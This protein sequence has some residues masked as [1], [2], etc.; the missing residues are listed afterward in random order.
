MLLV[1][2]HE[3]VAEGLARLLGD[4]PDI[5]PV[6]V[7]STIDDA[8]QVAR[9][10]RPDLVLMDYRLPDGDGVH[11]TRRL[12]EEVPD[13]NVVVLTAQP[14]E[15]VLEGALGAGACAFV[16]KQ[17]PAA[18]LIAAVRAA[19]AG[20][21]YFTPDVLTKLVRLRRRPGGTGTQTLHP[22]EREVLQLVADGRSVA[23]IAAELHLSPHTVRNHVRHAMQKLGVHTRLEA[24]VAA[25]RVGLVRLEP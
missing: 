18:D 13:A 17:A 23:Q 9:R 2:D 24:V 3:M 16:S 5:E 22:R 1:E 19:A 20:D 8:V 15:I 12:L 7:A 6:G 21:S 14:D 11:G 25:A 4:Q 10:Q